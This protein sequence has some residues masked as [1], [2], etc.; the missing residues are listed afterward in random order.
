MYKGTLY[1]IP[2]SLGNNDLNLTLPPKVLGII[3]EVDY[4]IV[5]NIKSAASF[6]KEGGI[7][8]KLQE[9]DFKVLNVNT[10]DEELYDY[11]N[12]ALEGH[13]IGII[14]EAGCPCIAD[15]GAKIVSLAHER[16]IKVVPLTGPS[17]VILALMASGLNGQS[18]TFHGYLP[19]NQKE[20]KEKLLLLQI[21]AFKGITQIFIEAPHRND[22]LLADI[23]AACNPELK[24][25]LA[26]D[27][28]MPDEYVQTKSIKL[29]ANDF[30]TIGKKPAI[31]L[32]CK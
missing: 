3:N 31:F 13:N 25:C 17:S 16:G 1:L 12:P 4:Y 6:L 14:S 27:L 22:N 28:T 23:L 24:L 11:L 29:W 5:E 15:P 9:L 20:R 2:S 30:L 8:K 10:R 7:K 26:V 19:I 21:E 32:I 18:F